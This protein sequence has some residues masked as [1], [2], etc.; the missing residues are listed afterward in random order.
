MNLARRKGKPTFGFDMTPMID[1]A[2]QLIIFFLFTSQLSH[3]MRS[4]MDLPEEKGDAMQAAS[5]GQVVVDVTR[6]GAYLIDG[7][8]RSL[9]DVVRLI[10]LEQEHVKATGKPLDLLVRADRACPALHVNTLALRLAGAGVRAW[11]LGTATP[12]AEAAP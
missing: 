2:L 4:S 10:T 3:A 9:E 11:K 7:T 12:R 6:D 1:V 5:P 8:E